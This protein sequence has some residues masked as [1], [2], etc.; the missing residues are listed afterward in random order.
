MPEWCKGAGPRQPRPVKRDE[1]SEPSRQV[2]RTV[3]FGLLPIAINGSYWQANDY[4]ELLFRT[5]LC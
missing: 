4:T 5:M 3:A 1:L 2:G